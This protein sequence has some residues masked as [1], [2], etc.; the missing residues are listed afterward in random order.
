MDILYIIGHNCSEIDYFE[1]RCSLRS[2]EKYGKN[3]SRIYVAG[4]CPDWL[5]DRVIKVPHEQLFQIDHNPS[6]E[7]ETVQNLTIKH[8]NMLDTLLYA[9]DNT[10]IGNEFLVSMDDHF[11]VRETDFDIYP[12]YRKRSC[13]GMLP[14]NGDTTYKEFLSYTREICELYNLS[15][16]YLTLHSNMHLSRNIIQECRPILNRIINERI[17]CE[18]NAFLLNYRYTKYNDFIPIKVQDVKLTNIESEWKIQQSN[19]DCFSTAD[20]NYDDPLYDYLL[21]LYPNKS[22]YEKEDLK[23]L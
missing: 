14:R 1:L 6:T 9:V 10:D 3:I 2:L 22:K 11:Y 4:Y 23:Q 21:T 15:S 13:G 20:F 7:E 8:C 18:F 5:S 16:F 12:F 17:P 19:R